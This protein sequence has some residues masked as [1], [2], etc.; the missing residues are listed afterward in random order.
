MTTINDTIRSNGLHGTAYLKKRNIQSVSKI[1]AETV[2][3][4]RIRHCTQCKIRINSRIVCFNIYIISISYQWECTPCILKTTAYGVLWF[5][6]IPYLKC[7]L[8][9]LAILILMR[10]FKKNVLHEWTNHVKFIRQMSINSDSRTIHFEKKWIWDCKK[11][12]FVHI[13]KCWPLNYVK[14][15]QVSIMTAHHLRV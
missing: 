7:S 14:I 11:L 4:P 1:V 9:N 13:G 15:L 5:S 6:S 12:R 10:L 8:L 2:I 3:H